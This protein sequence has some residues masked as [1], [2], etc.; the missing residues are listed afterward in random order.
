MFTLMWLWCD[1]SVD[2]VW[3]VQSGVDGV[4]WSVYDAHSCWEDE[5]GNDDWLHSVV[6]ASVHTQYS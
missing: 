2:P 5:D 6:I 3:C 1:T 4:H